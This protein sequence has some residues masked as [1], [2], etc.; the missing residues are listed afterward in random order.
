MEVSRKH[1]IKGERSERD[2]YVA[3]CQFV[4]TE[5]EAFEIAETKKRRGKVNIFPKGSYEYGIE[6]TVSNISPT[7]Q[8][9]YPYCV[10]YNVGPWIPHP[11]RGR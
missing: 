1:V 4:K 10:R 5:D 9:R 6:A 3:R 8:S 7:M 2:S 11:N